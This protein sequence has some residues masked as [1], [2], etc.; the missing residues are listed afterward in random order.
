MCGNHY[1]S[2]TVFHGYASRGFE[3][4]CRYI[5][6]TNNQAKDDK[7][8]KLVVTVLEITIESTST[9]RTNIIEDTSTKADS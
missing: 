2:K 6:R 4:P 1:W 7:T 5:F 3:I 8:R 9:G